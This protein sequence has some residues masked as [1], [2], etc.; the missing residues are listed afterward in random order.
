MQ[1]YAQVGMLICKV[2]KLSGDILTYNILNPNL[3]KL[4]Y[5]NHELIVSEIQQAEPNNIYALMWDPE[6]MLNNRRNNITCQPSIKV[7]LDSSW[8]CEHLNAIFFLRICY[9]ISLTKHGHMVGMS[10]CNQHL[11]YGFMAKI[12]Y[13]PCH[14]NQHRRI[15]SCTQ[16]TYYRYNKWKC[17]P[18]KH[19]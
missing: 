15:R 5:F 16:Y 10:V 13:F 2:K 6:G 9:S 1:S 18:M 12:S 7:T 8:N 19:L 3:K 4:S 14:S 17:R 11:L